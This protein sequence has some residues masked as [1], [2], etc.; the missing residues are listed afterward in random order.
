MPPKP[1]LRKRLLPEPPTD[2][3]AKRPLGF[4]DCLALGINGIIGSGIFFLPAVLQRHAGSASW[5]SW[6]VVGGLC[7]VVALCFAEAASR[8]TQ[9]GGP[10]R[11]AV[12]AF[13]RY[14]GFGV[15]W[16]T[17]TS[18]VLGYAAVARGFAEHGASLAGTTSAPALVAWVVALVGGLGALNAWGIRPSARTGD[19]VGGAKLVALAGFVLFG[20]WALHRGDG[21]SLTAPSQPVHGVVAGAMAGLFA[22]TGFEY[23]PV[24]A[25]ETKRP[26][27]LVGLAMVLSLCVSVAVYALVQRVFSGAASWAPSLAT[28]KTPLADAAGVLGG[29]FFARAVSVL[30]MVS[31]F[32]FCT[33]SALVAPRY[34][35]SFAVDGFLP[36]LLGRRLSRRNTPL[37]AIVA[38]SGL[39]LGLAGTVDFGSLADISTLAVV[40]QYASTCA[41]V[42]VL[43]QRRGRAPFTLPLGPL[44]PLL[45]LAGCVVFVSQVARGELLLAA[46]LLGAGV[47]VAVVSRVS[48]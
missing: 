25:G 17:L 44:L 35:E 21:P 34:V 31:S 4:V 20:A 33:G 40:A 18:S 1:D 19:V 39:V 22:C 48:R 10:Y 11:Y 43:R 15:G 28:S 5:L 12:D 27:R 36:S 42:L 29:S 13:G 38:V 2:D 37:W 16:I 41:A 7:I 23:V 8:T 32:G 47:V 45:G 6:L 24:P 3:D 26:E 46:A 9:S 30:A 14:A